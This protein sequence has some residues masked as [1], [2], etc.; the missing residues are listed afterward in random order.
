M[1]VY[2]T[3][4]AGDKLSMKKIGNRADYRKKYRNRFRI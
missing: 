1:Q 3:G 4:T 2:C